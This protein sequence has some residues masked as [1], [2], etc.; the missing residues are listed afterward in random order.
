MRGG[1]RPGTPRPAPRPSGTAPRTPSQAGPPRV[2]CVCWRIVSET[3]TRYGSVVPAERQAA[4]VR[5]VPGE[6][7]GAEARDVEAG[8]DA[9]ARSSDASLPRRLAFDQ[10]AHPGPG[11]PRPARAGRSRRRRTRGTPWPPSAPSRSVSST[12]IGEPARRS[13]VAVA[14]DQPLARPTTP[15]GDVEAGVIP[16]RHPA[17]VDAALGVRRDVVERQQQ[18]GEVAERRGQPAALV[19]RSHRVALEVDEDEPAGRPEELSEMEVA[20]DPG[21]QRFVPGHPGSAAARAP[22]A[23]RGSPA[24]RRG[25]RPRHRVRRRGDRVASPSALARASACHAARSAG[26]A[27]A[28]RTPRR[29]RAPARVAWSRATVARARRRPRSRTRARRRRARRSSRSAARRSIS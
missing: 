12:T 11:R 5:V 2:T 23:G 24:P 22:R 27:A 3:S 17:A 21:Q 7:G 28:A 26:S 9:P 19:D 25:S 16:R 18:A 1:R 10:P 20:V 15:G 4:T 8:A 29:R 14:A 13:R 6:D